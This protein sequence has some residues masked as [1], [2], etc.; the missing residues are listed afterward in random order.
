MRIGINI[1]S[2]FPYQEVID[3]LVENG[4]NHTFVCI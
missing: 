3:T 4:I 2:K 1:D